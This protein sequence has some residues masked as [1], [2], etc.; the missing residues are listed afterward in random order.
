MCEPVLP[1]HVSAIVHGAG[2]YSSV[3]QLLQRWVVHLPEIYVEETLGALEATQIMF[4]S[5]VR[6]KTSRD[7]LQY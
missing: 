2:L 7:D 4:H 1:P 6:Q 5:P 3:D